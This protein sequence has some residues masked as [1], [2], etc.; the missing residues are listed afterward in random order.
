MRSLEWLLRNLTSV[1]IRNLSDSSLDSTLTLD[2]PIQVEI[3]LLGLDSKYFSL[4]QSPNLENPD[5]LV[6]RSNFSIPISISHFDIIKE[7]NYSDSKGKFI[8]LIT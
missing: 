2:V 1:I 6:V 8:L 7:N 4:Y 3:S 5:R